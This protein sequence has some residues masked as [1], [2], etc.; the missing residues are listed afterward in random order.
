MVAIKDTVKLFYKY[1]IFD[2]K[3]RHTHGE[4]IHVCDTSWYTRILIT[5]LKQWE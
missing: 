3:D 5:T 1:G 2:I 4:Y